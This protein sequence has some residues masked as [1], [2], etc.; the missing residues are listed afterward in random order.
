MFFSVQVVTLYFDF[1]STEEGVDVLSIYDGS[2]YM[3]T[4]LIVALSGSNID[5]LGPYM[6][7]QPDM[8]LRFVTNSA[9][10]YPGFSAE[11]GTTTVGGS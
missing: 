7:T 2:F 10:N 1:F 4:P 8:Y 3:D 9:N 5:L 6:S 11:Y